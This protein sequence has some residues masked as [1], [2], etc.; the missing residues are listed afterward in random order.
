VPEL[1]G[2]ASSQEG[3]MRSK[4]GRRERRSQAQWVEV[5]RR[6]RAS[7]QGAR[8]FCRREGLAL[9]SFQRWRQRLGTGSAPEFVELVSAPASKSSLTTS[10]SLDVALPNGVQLHFRG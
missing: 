4:R 10:W 5:F 9:S 8:A 7:G 6:F 2:A 3:K 1:T